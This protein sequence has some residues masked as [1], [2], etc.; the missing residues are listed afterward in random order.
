LQDQ[1]VDRHEQ[2]AAN[3]VL[4]CFPVFVCNWTG[5]FGLA[6]FSNV[7]NADDS[8]HYL[9]HCFPDIRSVFFIVWLA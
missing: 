2:L 5:S 8:I 9:S 3:V 1:E 7:Q 4:W 6:P